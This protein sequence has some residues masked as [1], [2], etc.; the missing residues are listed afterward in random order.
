MITAAVTKIKTGYPVFICE[1]N[2]DSQ[3]ILSAKKKD[4]RDEEAVA[5]GRYFNQWS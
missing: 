1:I 4:E 3:I 5:E 2:L